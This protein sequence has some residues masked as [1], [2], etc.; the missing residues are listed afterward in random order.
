MMEPTFGKATDWPMAVTHIRAMV[1]AVPVDRTWKPAPSTVR[2]MPRV[3]IRTSPYFS[4]RGPVRNICEIAAEIPTKAKQIP[5]S[6]GVQPN[7]SLAQSPK[8]DSM[9]VKAKP[10]RKVRSIRRPRTGLCTTSS[11]ADQRLTRWAAPSRRW[12]LSRMKTRMP[13]TQRAAS[14]EATNSGIRKPAGPASGWARSPPR[15][16]PTIMPT[17]QAAPW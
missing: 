17:F 3:S 14:P 9:P 12:L 7:R 4:E 2:I 11:M 1:I 5:I 15:E 6:R 13:S 10:T 16:G 8:V